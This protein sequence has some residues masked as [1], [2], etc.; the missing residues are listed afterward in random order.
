MSRDREL[1]SGFCAMN[2][3]YAKNVRNIFLPILPAPTIRRRP[4]RFAT[5]SFFH[6]FNL[7]FDQIKSIPA[8]A[9]AHV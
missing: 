9:V 1:V 4:M 2:G 3:A 6:S 7:D 5:V 8:L